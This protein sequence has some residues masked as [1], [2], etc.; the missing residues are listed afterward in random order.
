MAPAGSLSG[1]V[2][3]MTGGTLPASI[4]SLRTCSS[5]LL[6]LVASVRMVWPTNSD[7]GTALMLPVGGPDEATLHGHPLTMRA[8]CLT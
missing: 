8:M 5:S 3:S 2:V 4:S 1:Y 7:N 6:G